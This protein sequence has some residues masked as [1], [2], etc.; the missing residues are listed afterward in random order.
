MSKESIYRFIGNNVLW[1]RITPTYAYLLFYKYVFYH[2]SQLGDNNTASL[3]SNAKHLYNIYTMVDQ[4]RRCVNV[5][6]M[7]CVCWAK[8]T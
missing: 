4:R 6:H 1:T 5:I 7:F 2:L 3:P 8:R